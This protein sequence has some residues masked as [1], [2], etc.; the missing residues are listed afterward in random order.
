VQNVALW[1]GSNWQDLDGGFNAPPSALYG[2]ESALI[3]GGH[4][5]LAGDEEVVGVARYDHT[6]EWHAMGELWG[7]AQDFE[8]YNTSLYACGAFHWW[9]DPYV[10]FFALARWTGAEWIPDP[11]V[12]WSASDEPFKMDTYL[13]SLFL[14]GDVAGGIV[15]FDGDDTYALGSII[16]SVSDIQYKGNNLYVGGSFGEAGGVETRDLAIVEPDY[17]Y[18]ACQEPHE[19][20]NV[21][22]LTVMND[23]LYV[24]GDKH[25]W[26]YGSSG[27]SQPLGG[28]FEDYIFCMEARNPGELFVGGNMDHGVL[29][30]D[31]DEWVQVGG[32]FGRPGLNAWQVNCLVNFDGDVVAGGEFALPHVLTTDWAGNIARW[33]GDG[34]HRFGPGLNQD[35]QALIVYQGELIAGGQFWAIGGSGLDHIARW[36]GETWQEYGQADSDIADFAIYQGNLIATGNFQEIGGVPAA[37]IA[38]FDGV[39]WQPLG[40]GLDHGPFTLQVYNGYLVA[41]GYFTTA[42]GVAAAGVARWNGSTWEAMGDG[43]DG[44]VRDLA[45]WQGVLYAGGKFTMSGSQPLSNLARWD[46]SSWQPVGGGVETS[47]PIYGVSALQPT[48]A[49]LIVGGGFHTA[50]GVP[51]HGL[52]AW[53]G[54]SWQEI[55]GGI[56]EGNNDNFR[57]FDFLVKDGHL[58]IGGDFTRVS[59]TIPSYNMALWYDGTLTPRF[60]QTFDARVVGTGERPAV[61]IEWQVTADAA[62]DD[63]RLSARWQDEVW[64]VPHAAAEGEGWFAALDASARLVGAEQVIYVLEHR[65]ANG[66]WAELDRQEVSLAAV[67]F[68]PRL[69]VHPNPFNPQTTV[70]FTL[71]RPQ[72]ITLAVYATTGRKVTTLASGPVPS[73]GHEYHW[74]GRDAMGRNVASGTYL[75][76]L[77]TKSTVQAE[78]VMLVR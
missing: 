37:R 65:S 59:N 45:V 11:H 77:Q 27:W 53:D 9:Y 54:A 12:N 78:K 39:S 23:W 5:D 30:W 32:G 64:F 20:R 49:E 62:K 33:D 3:A 1:N 75:I 73:G 66:A 48:T 57:V 67:P 46:G 61:E 38:A 22:A 13:G 70:R 35:V 44:H 28:E 16:G 6:N 50:G 25:V 52:A 71:D 14:G 24:A 60:L 26:R 69:V 36:D 43:F 15:R 2:A 68:R 34:W 17:S 40:S 41:G 72:Q 58:Y 56:H 4:F 8:F 10:Q 55:G 21:V 63:F 51:A 19:A 74:D 76:R 29:R 7:A 31:D 42:G 47:D 18:R